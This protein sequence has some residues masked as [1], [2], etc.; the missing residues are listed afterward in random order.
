MKRR[1]R[2]HPVWSVAERP[3][4]LA[5]VVGDVAARHAKKHATA[6]ATAYVTSAMKRWLAGLLG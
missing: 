2:L 6:Y 3:P 5:L 4:V 1:R